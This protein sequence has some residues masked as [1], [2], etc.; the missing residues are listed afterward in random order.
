MGGPRLNLLSSYWSRINKNIQIAAIIFTKHCRFSF[1]RLVWIES[2]YEIIKNIEKIAFEKSLGMPA[3]RHAI[4]IVILII[5]LTDNWSSKSR[6]R[7]FWTCFWM[8]EP[9]YKNF[10]LKVRQKSVKSIKCV[11]FSVHEYF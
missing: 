7:Y 9:K 1:G 3:A 6:T 8:F 4:K 10:P 5:S 2:N 11:K